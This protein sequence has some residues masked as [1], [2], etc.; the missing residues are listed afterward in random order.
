MTDPKHPDVRWHLGV[1][2]RIAGEPSFAAT[3]EWPGYVKGRVE[4]STI[5]FDDAGE[6]EGELHSAHITIKGRVA[7]QVVGGV[8][9]LHASA[10]VT[11]EITEERLSIEAGAQFAGHCTSRPFIPAT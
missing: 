6:V 4:A 11:G 3:V 7:G 10:R 2:S 9:A 5:V 1:G 8:G